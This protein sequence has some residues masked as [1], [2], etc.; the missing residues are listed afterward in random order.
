MTYRRLLHL[1]FSSIPEKL[2][3]QIKGAFLSL[4]GIFLRLIA[5]RYIIHFRKIFENLKKSY[6]ATLGLVD[7]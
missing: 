2:L 7:I 5:V 6:T 3:L 4:A 1:T